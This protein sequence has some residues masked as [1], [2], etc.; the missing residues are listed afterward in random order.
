IVDEYKERCEKRHAEPPIFVPTGVFI[1]TARW[2]GPTDVLVTGYVWQRYDAAAKGLSRGFSVQSAADVKI[3]EAYREK[4]GDAEVIRW[5]LQAVLHQKMGF[6]EYPLDQETIDLFLRHQD[7]DHNVVLVPDL[8]A[9]KI[10][11]AAAKPG[12][13]ADFLVPGWEVLKSYFQL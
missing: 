2:T 11:S 8:A 5:S 7:L 9:Y 6:S 10:V 4:D 1:Q 12:L 3:A 13:A